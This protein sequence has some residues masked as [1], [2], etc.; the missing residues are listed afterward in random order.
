VAVL[1]TLGVAWA[2]AIVFGPVTY[3]AAV[4]LLFLLA[5]RRFLPALMCIALSPSGVVLILAVASYLRGTAKLHAHG[6]P[7]TEFHNVDPDYRC[8]WSTGGCIV[9]GAEWMTDGAN[10]LALTSLIKLFGPQRG[11][12][13]GPYPIEQETRTA[14]ADAQVISVD[15]LLKDVVQIGPHTFKLDTGVGKALLRFT[16][17]G[18]LYDPREPDSTAL[19]EIRKSLGPLKASMIRE[20]CIVIRIPTDDGPVDG[21]PSARIAVVDA[22]RGRPFAYYGEGSYFHR[23]PPVRWERP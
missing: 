20:S 13:L 6:L 4:P 7:G 8:G 17:M 12:Y 22:V 16:P 15:Q 1:L 2:G 18:Y 21:R 5:R 3:L 19:D 11:S 23:V 10:N 14:L 9:N